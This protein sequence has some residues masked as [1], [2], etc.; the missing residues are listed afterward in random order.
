VAAAAVAKLG[1]ADG[2]KFYDAW[3]LSK[4]EAGVG[5]LGLGHKIIGE[6]VLPFEVISILLLGALIGAVVIV[7]KELN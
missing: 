3:L 1:E 2:A 6:Y 7:R 4:G 5:H